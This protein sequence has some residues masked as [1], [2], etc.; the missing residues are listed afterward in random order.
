MTRE[1]NAIVG[2]VWVIVFTG[3]AAAAVYV[4]T[5]FAESTKLFPFFIGFI[6]GISLTI[7]LVK[8]FDRRRTSESHPRASSGRA[9]LSS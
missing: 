3:S 9:N 7:L 5:R 6:L 4:A 1:R 8:L 2:L